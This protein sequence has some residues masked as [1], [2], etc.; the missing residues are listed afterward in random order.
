MYVKDEIFFDPDRP[1]PEF[2][3]FAQNANPNASDTG[4]SRFS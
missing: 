4:G 2:G 1:H 3:L